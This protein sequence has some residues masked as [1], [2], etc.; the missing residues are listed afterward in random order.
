MPQL[1]QIHP[2]TLLAVSCLSNAHHLG[3]SQNCSHYGSHGYGFYPA[4]LE[5]KLVPLSL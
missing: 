2:V 4:Y 1:L 3:L 5:Y